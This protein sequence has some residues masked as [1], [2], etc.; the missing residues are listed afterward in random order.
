MRLRNMSLNNRLKLL[1]RPT[2]LLSTLQPL[3]LSKRAKGCKVA[4]TCNSV[5]GG[6]VSLTVGVCCVG[7][8]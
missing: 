1:A 7:K 8:L 5:C 2:V 3:A 6:C 4:L